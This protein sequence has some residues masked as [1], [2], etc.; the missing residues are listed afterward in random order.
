MIRRL[1]LDDPEERMPFKHEPLNKRPDFN[2]SAMDQRRCSWGNHWAYVPV[3]PKWVLNLIM[4]GYE[5]I[6]PLY[7]ARLQKEKIH[8]HSADAQ[9]F[10]VELAS[11]WRASGGPVF[12]SSILII[13]WKT[14]TKALVDSLLASA[15]GENGLRWA[16]LARYADTR[17]MNVI[18]SG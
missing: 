11:M 6:W 13:N 5:M 17:V 16:D 3:Q 12:Q 1:T 9:P 4:N 10:C 8:Q 18:I 15:Y 7:L 2:A 14:H